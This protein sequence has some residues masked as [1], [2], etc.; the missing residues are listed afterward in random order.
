M[1]TSRGTTLCCSGII[2]SGKDYGT[3]WEPFLLVSE[4]Q[5]SFS[6]SFSLTCLWSTRRTVVDTLFTVCFWTWTIPVKLCADQSMYNNDYLLCVCGWINVLIVLI[7]IFHQF[8]VEI[9]CLS[10]Q[11]GRSTVSTCTT[12]W[13]T[14][15]NSYICLF[16][17]LCI[18]IKNSLS[19]LFPKKHFEAGMFV[20]PS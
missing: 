2:F 19:W 11:V 18:L 20:K 15:T 14:K 1:A 3:F 4:S 12:V 16:I 13:I 8:K 6:V 7:L 5:A 10:A 17:I 9:V